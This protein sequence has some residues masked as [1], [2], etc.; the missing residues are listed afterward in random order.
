VIDSVLGRN[1]FVHSYSEVERSVIMDNCHIR[2]NTRI[3]NVIMDKNVEVPEGEEIGY[4]LEK[5]RKRFA[6]TESG[7]VVIPKDYVFD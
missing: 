6:V 3:R 1:V 4:N 5:D 2:R 7:L